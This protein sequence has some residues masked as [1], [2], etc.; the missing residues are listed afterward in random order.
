MWIF[1]DEL[2]TCNSMGLI[3]EIFCNRTMRGKKI[4]DDKYQRYVFIG[5]CN[6]YRILSEK[7]KKLEIGLKINNK[8]KKD[9]VYTV[10]PLPHSLLN[11]VIDFG[12]LTKEDTKSYIE[13]MIK[14][15]INDDNNIE[16]NS[17]LV[18]LAVNT[19]K[20]C[21]FFIKNNSDSSSVSLRDIKHF[22]I[23]YKG[24][25]KY[26]EYLKD[27]SRKQNIGIITK[28][29]HLNEF[30]EMNSYTIK[31]NS[32]NLSIYISY[33][34]RLPTKSLREELCKLLDEQNYFEYGFLHVPLKESKFILDQ[35]YINPQ[36]GIAKNNALRE[37]IFCELFCLINKIPLIICGKPGNSKSL[38]VQLLLDNMKGKLSLNEFFKNPDYKEVISYPFQGST[39]CTSNGISSFF[40][41]SVAF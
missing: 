40:R 32:I 31:K 10:N 29:P 23:F 33:Y 17:R 14:N 35:I 3:S 7:S 19:V 28:N 4:D 18:K 6:P 27:L 26:F 36:R 12:E 9:L 5:A 16:E 20:L 1:F 8:R 38:S 15:Y 22:N 30:S 21:H 41:R 39:T 25:I 34:L 24:F 11:Y 37:N 13:S 2:N